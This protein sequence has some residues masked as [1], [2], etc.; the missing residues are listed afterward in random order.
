M[1]APDFQVENH[2]SIILLRPATDEAKQWLNFNCAPEPWQWFG[3]A[4]AVEPRCAS[5]LIEGLRE[6]GFTVK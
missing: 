3:G 5:N 1:I 4:M 2:G 6:E